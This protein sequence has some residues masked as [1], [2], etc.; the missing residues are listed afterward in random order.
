MRDNF[1]TFF[2]YKKNLWLLGEIAV[3]LSCKEDCQG[4]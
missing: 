2:F 4:Q 3:F 1:L